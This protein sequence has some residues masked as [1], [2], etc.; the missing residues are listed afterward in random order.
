M[1]LPE[2]KITLGEFEREKVL[3]TEKLGKFASPINKLPVNPESNNMRELFDVR[4]VEEHKN[5]DADFERIFS[6]RCAAL[7][8]DSLIR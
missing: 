2:P 7:A 5:V 8:V 3:T 1:G 6:E 4:L